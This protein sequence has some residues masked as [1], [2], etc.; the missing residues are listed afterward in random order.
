MKEAKAP[1]PETKPFPAI[2]VN[3]ED[4]H[5]YDIVSTLAWFLTQSVIWKRE[6]TKGGKPIIDS[7][8]KEQKRSH[9]GVI[10]DE[11]EQFKKRFPNVD[12]K[13][14]W[15]V[16]RFVEKLEAL[17]VEHLGDVN[18]NGSWQPT[19]KEAEQ[20]VRDM[21]KL[22]I[23]KATNTEPPEDV[24]KRMD[25][26]QKPKDTEGEPRKSDDGWHGPKPTPEPEK[27]PESP[28][29]PNPPEPEK[30]VKPNDDEGTP[31][32]PEIPPQKPEGEEE[33]FPLP[34]EEPVKPEPIHREPEKPLQP[35]KPETR[36]RLQET[37]K[38]T[39]RERIGSA[40]NSFFDAIQRAIDYLLSFLPDI[41]PRQRGPYKHRWWA[42]ALGVGGPVGV[43]LYALLV[44]FGVPVLIAVGVALILPLYIAI[45]DYFGESD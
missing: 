38:K 15:S 12:F 28:T 26:M 45:A 1:Q 14:D 44:Y 17:I 43:G 27:P 39:L 25:E 16:N 32:T 31:T 35:K 3:P 19:Y 22:L 13:V 41:G 33:P 36:F 29:P 24:K 23:A 7:I 8:T 42:G 4:A 34:V 10:R 40:V 9:S 11:Y 37:H 20:Y 30:P 5:R 18:K 21:C 2:P 6:Y